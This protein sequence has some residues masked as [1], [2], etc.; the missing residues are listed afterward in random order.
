MR[1]PPLMSFMSKRSGR[2]RSV[3]SIAAFTADASCEVGFSQSGF[4]GL[5][6]ASGHD[7]ITLSAG[8]GGVGTGVGVGAGTGACVGLAV[9]LPPQLAARNDDESASPAKTLLRIRIILTSESRTDE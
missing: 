5:L 8:G 9:L 4:D 7:G 3:R 6:T 2:S 1:G